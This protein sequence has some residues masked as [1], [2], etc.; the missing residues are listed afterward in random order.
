M[1]TVMFFPL[2]FHVLSDTF[3]IQLLLIVNL[4]IKRCTVTLVDN[5]HQGW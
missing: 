5:S 3:R 2:N 4:Q 1:F